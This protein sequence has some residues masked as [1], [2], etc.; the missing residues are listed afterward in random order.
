M[1]ISY[2]FIY[3]FFLSIL[4]ILSF[5]EFSIIKKNKKPSVIREICI[6]I[7]I[8][9]WALRGYVVGDAMVYGWHF[10][11][12]PSIFSNKFWNYL[13]LVSDKGFT[14]LMGIT[15]IIS[16]DYL[17]FQACI[18][19]LTIYL[20]DKVVQRYS[21]YYVLPVLLFF[22]FNGLFLSFNL[23]RNCITILLFISSIKY[24]EE[25]RFSRFLI[26]NI[27]GVFIHYSSIIY[28]ILYPFFRIKI[29]TKIFWIIFIV[30]NI[31]FLAK[32]EYVKLILGFIQPFLPGKIGLAVKAYMN[33]RHELKPF[34]ITFGFFERF[35]TVVIL[36]L[37]RRYFRNEKYVNIFYNML[38]IYIIGFY[39]FGELSNLMGRMM[40]LFVGFYWFLF[41]ILYA[42]FSRT[43]KYWFLIIFPLICFGK[44]LLQTRTPLFEYS[45]I[46]TGV[47]SFREY[48]SRVENI[49]N[50]QPK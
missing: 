41:P 24:I 36:L 29:S 39:F 35:V 3:L 7:L 48:Q 33:I 50:E 20:L 1:N 23:I 6:F 46:I 31:I 19:L 26:I 28:I 32:I 45:N 27:I 4:I 22:S 15:R 11:A 16:K 30:G 34:S 44:M 12:L 14:I 38:L 13:L 10:N 42:K 5:V 17:F 40:M 21:K 49:Y 25:K 9:F 47:E 37:L 18:G 43:R 2:T 8:V